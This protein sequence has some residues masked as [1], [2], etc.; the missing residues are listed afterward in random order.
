MNLSL[1]CLVTKNKFFLK[2]KKKK[3][4]QIPRRILLLDAGA[5]RKIVILSIEEKK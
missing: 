5:Q 2:G 4:V 1:S 3:L